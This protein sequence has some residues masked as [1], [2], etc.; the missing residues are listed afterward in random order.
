MP[1]GVALAGGM[2]LFGIAMTVLV[3]WLIFGGVAGNERGLVF[4]NLTSSPVELRFQ[5]G[6]LT[7]LEPDRE[8]TLPV[9][10][11]QFPQIFSV[12]DSL[13]SL[14]YQQEYRFEQFKDIEFRIGIGDTGFITVM[15]PTTN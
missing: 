4:K 10:R 12:Y 7:D 8:Q 6:R 5:D 15:L 11:T 9:K 3:G 1:K 2:V 13:G 14:R